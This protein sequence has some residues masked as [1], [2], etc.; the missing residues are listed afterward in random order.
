MEVLYNVNPYA[1]F[2]RTACKV[3]NANKAKSF[4][5]QGI[6]RP[7]VDPKRYNKSTAYEVAVIVQGNG[8]II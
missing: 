1:K 2:F 5:L 8:D 7:G 4:K 3:L 6:P